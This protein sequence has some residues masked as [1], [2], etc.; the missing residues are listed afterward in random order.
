MVLYHL[1]VISS[2]YSNMHVVQFFIQKDNHHIYI[3]IQWTLNSLPMYTLVYQYR[4]FCIRS[5]ISSSILKCI[6]SDSKLN[7]LFS[8]SYFFSEIFLNTFFFF[9]NRCSHNHLLI[10]SAFFCFYLLSSLKVN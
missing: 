3:S 6:G 9:R 1:K 5:I 4:Y 7:V 2:S 8:L 10:I